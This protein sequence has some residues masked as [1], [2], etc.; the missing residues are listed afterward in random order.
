[1]QVMW[2]KRDLRTADNAALAAAAEC[3]PVLPLYVAEPEW[4]QGPDMSARQWAFAAESLIELRDDLARAGAP[5][6]VRT[7]DVTHVLQ[8]LLERGHLTALWS[9]EETG[10]DWTYA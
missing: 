9:H 3:G 4:W 8:D 2:F 10:N 6:V 1:M 5:L 7:G